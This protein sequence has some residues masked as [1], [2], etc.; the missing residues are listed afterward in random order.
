MSTSRRIVIITFIL[1]MTCANL[2]KV[3]QNGYKYHS[4]VAL[5][6]KESQVDNFCP[7]SEQLTFFEEKSRRNKK[8][9]T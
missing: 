2:N 6:L 3:I 4:Y 5:K 8:F 9:K 7:S 1:V